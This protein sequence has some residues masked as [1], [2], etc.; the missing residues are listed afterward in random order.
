MFGART[1]PERQVDIVRAGNV[2]NG[3]PNEVRATPGQPV[4]NTTKPNSKGFPL[5]GYSMRNSCA[6][7]KKNIKRR[8]P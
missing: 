5:Q 6:F 2:C 8:M 7:V 3:E 1:L 4:K